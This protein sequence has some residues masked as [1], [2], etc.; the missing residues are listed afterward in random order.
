ML[1]YAFFKL[2]NF[3]VDIGQI[4]QSI[5]KQVKNPTFSKKTIDERQV[6]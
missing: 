3:C 2:L 5:S 6:G 4:A 1:V